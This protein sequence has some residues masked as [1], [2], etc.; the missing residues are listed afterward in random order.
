MQC[1]NCNM[2][3][4]QAAIY[5]SFQC[6]YL[7]NKV[8]QNTTDHW[9]RQHVIIPFHVS[10]VL[11][12]KVIKYGTC[13]YRLEQQFRRFCHVIIEVMLIPVQVMPIKQSTTQ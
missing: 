6:K 7:E 10:I 13:Q 11:A 4:A 8:K 3:T 9:I 1:V 12:V 5:D 2:H